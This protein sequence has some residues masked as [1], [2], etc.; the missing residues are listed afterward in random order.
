MYVY[1]CV[2]V[3]HMKLYAILSNN[4]KQIANFHGLWKKLLVIVC[5]QIGSLLDCDSEEMPLEDF[6]LNLGLEV[7]NTVSN[8]ETYFHAA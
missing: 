8:I 7:E 4:K 5:E 2:Y 1:M 6:F 3:K